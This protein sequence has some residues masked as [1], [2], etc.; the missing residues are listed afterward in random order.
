MAAYP[1]LQRDRR[2]H[3]R[4]AQVGPGRR[5]ADAAATAHC[6]TC[7]AS[8]AALDAFRA[9]DGVV[10]FVCRACQEFWLEA[11]PRNHL[12]VGR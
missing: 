2:Q 6:P 7:A 10:E 1:M 12:N 5:L 4:R 11:E 3:E 9:R 8:A